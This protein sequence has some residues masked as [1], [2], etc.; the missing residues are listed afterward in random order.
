MENLSKEIRTELQALEYTFVELL[1]IKE[2][3]NRKPESLSKFRKADRNILRAKKRIER[4][5]QNIA[6]DLM[7]YGLE[8]AEINMLM[9]EARN[10]A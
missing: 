10:P 5:T 3:L 9:I 4:I 2:S 1:R 7:A 8:A 6:S